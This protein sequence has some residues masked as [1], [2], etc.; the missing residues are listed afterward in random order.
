MP[1]ITESAGQI[2]ARLSA[3]IIGQDR[4]IAQIAPRIAQWQEEPAPRFPLRLLFAGPT[5][6]GKQLLASSIAHTLFSGR[7][8]VHSWLALPGPLRLNH[9]LRTLGPGPLVL[10]LKLFDYGAHELAAVET[11]LTAGGII[12]GNGQSMALSD[13][14]VILSAS[15]NLSVELADAARRE[16]SEGWTCALAARFPWIAD[17]LDGAVQLDPLGPDELA[18]IVARAATAISERTGIAI[19]VTDAA[20]RAVAT[21]QTARNVG[22]ALARTV[23]RALANPEVRSQLQSEGRTLLVDHAN[24]EFRMSPA[25]AGGHLPVRPVAARS[26]RADI[27]ASDAPWFKPPPRPREFPA[28]NW[29]GEYEFDAFISYKIRKHLDAARELRDALGRAGYKVWLDEDQIGAADDPWHTKTKEHLIDRLVRGVVGSRCTIVFEAQL[30]AVALPPGWSKADAEAR[31]NV[32]HSESGA[33]IAWNWQ[34]L[35]IDSSSRAIV[36]RP[37]RPHLSV[38]DGVHDITR[39]VLGGKEIAPSELAPAIARAIDHFKNTRGL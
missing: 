15:H 34:K 4:A 27:E 5:S 24:G 1:G 30:E 28:L 21:N 14:I 7:F 10:L 25:P 8:V 36:I 20:A 9:K 18:E 17:G 22:N 11:L 33:L 13:S 16:P 19:A 39:T 23:A 38:F 35:E 26:A 12:L 2:A 32:M 37:N 29:R 6:V 31:G 3:T